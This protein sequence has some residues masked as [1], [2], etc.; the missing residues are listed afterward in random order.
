V[1][2]K[3]V[4]ASVAALALWTFSVK[5]E[6]V[7]SLADVTGKWSGVGSRGGKTDIT[8]ES[9]GRFVIESPAGRATGMARLEDGILVLPFSNNQGQVRF[10][11]TG[12]ALEGPYV[13]GTLTGT[14]RVRRTGK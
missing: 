7:T 2:K 4:A 10:A 14:T 8:I 11:R 3:L 1:L 12:E 6:P 5:A 13:I 9:D